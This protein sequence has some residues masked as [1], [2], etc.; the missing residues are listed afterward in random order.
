MPGMP[1]P[2]WFTRVL[3]SPPRCTSL[4]RLRR[5]LEGKTVL[6]TGA[7][8]GIGEATARLC[9]QAGAEVILL[10]RS[11][12]RLEA[13]A[14]EIRQAGGRA[15]TWTAD[16]TQVDAV[17]A[18]ARALQA[19]HPRID[20]VV[21]NAGLSISR[22]LLRS[23]ER[24]DLQ[25]SLAVNLGSPALLLSVLLPRMLAQPGG[26]QVVNVSS[27]A[28]RLNPAPRWAA[29]LSSKAGF[30]VWLRSVA[31]ECRAGGVRCASVYLPLVR[32]RMIA[33]T[34]AYDRWPALHPQEAAEAVAWALVTGHS[35][36]APW[37]LGLAELLGGLL[38]RPIARVMAY[39]ASRSRP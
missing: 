26:G 17:P 37:W 12:E 2:A 6:V 27:V 9:A 28:A 30:D 16:L 32:T 10:A 7:S 31:A 11:A 39:R 25:R 23:L 14:A 34:R 8:F 20:V 19:R 29:Y 4:P 24:A 5:V 18:W 38:D 3:L 36:V 22:P 1:W 33:P 21:S 35:R 13:V 15:S